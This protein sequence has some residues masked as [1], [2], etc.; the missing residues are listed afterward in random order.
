MRVEGA[1]PPATVIRIVP[2]VPRGA[3][4]RLGDAMARHRRAIVAVQWGVVLVY[5]VLVAV[6]LFLLKDSY[7]Y[8]LVLWLPCLALPLAW[9]RGGVHREWR[10]LATAVLCLYLVTAGAEW[11]CVLLDRWARPAEPGWTTTA[12]SALLQL[13]A[14]L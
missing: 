11:P 1:S 10:W 4:A 12:M 13:S 5:A 8:R 3:L 2:R 6:P 9:L 14:L 7:D